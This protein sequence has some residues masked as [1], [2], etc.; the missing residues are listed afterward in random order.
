MKKTTP[1]PEVA[2][3]VRHWMPEATDEE[4]KQATVNLRNYLV[5][6]YRIFL[7][8]EAKS[9]PPRARDNSSISDRVIGN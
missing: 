5:V 2:E 8:L 6:V 7:R 1:I 9:R 3:I 4:L